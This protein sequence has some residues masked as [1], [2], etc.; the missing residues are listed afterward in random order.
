MATERTGFKVLKKGWKHYDH[1]YTLGRNIL[2]GEFKTESE[3]SAGGLYFVPDSVGAAGVLRWIILNADVVCR[4]TVP[5]D[6]QVHIESNGKAK[7]SVLILS[8]PLPVGD[9]LI[10]HGIELAAVQ[11]DGY[12]LVHI[13]E[14][15][16]ELCLAAVQQNGYTL[17]YVKEQ[18]P[19]LCLAA[20][21]QNGGALQFVKEQTP[22]Q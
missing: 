4:V 7:A 16:P 12:A 21:Q 18:T 3:C 6:A 15:T 11:K 2:N 20:V 5:D 10:A 9:F 17:N 22:E 14:Q 8:D 13:K 19:A 1:T